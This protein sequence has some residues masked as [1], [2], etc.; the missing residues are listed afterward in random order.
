MGG[1]LHAIKSLYHCLEIFSKCAT[2]ILGEFIEKEGLVE[3]YETIL[4]GTINLD[5]LT[6]EERT[7]FE[8]MKT[9]AEKNPEWPDLDEL[10]YKRLEETG[11]LKKRT[12]FQYAHQQPL[13]RLYSDV[14][15][16]LRLK[17]WEKLKQEQENNKK[18][19]S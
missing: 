13:C 18:A 3:K 6:L 12:G 17:Q 15:L 4:H 7:I 9:S 16:R 14:C 1:K 5:D 2:K 11:A 8:E 10:F 19:V